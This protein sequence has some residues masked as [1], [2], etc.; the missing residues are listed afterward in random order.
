MKFIS[1]SGFLMTTKIISLLDVE[2]FL[3]GFLLLSLCAGILTY[4]KVGLARTFLLLS[5]Y[6][7]LLFGILFLN[8]SNN[9]LTTA[10]KSL[11]IIFFIFST[12]YLIIFYTY[13]KQGFLVVQTGYVLLLMLSILGMF[14][15]MLSEDLFFWFLAIELQSFTFY[16]L[17]AYQTNRAFLQTEAALK[18]FIFGS[19]ASSFLLYGLSIIFLETGSLQVV[20]IQTILLTTED[21]SQLRTGIILVLIA[22][23]IKLGCAPFHLWTPQ[24]YTNSAP[25]LTF[26]FLLLPKIP[27]FY[28]LYVF[29]SL[30]IQN[31]YSFIIIASLLI[32]TIYAFSSVIFRTFMA[33]SAIANNAFLLTPL[34]TNSLFS[35]EALI[36]YIVMYNIVLTSIFCV[37][38][39][40]RRYD[41]TPLINNLRDLALVK[42]TNLF[43]AISLAIAF[44][45]F[46]GIPPLIGFS[47]KIIVLTSSLSE[48][49]YTINLVLL[50]ASLLSAYYYLRVLKT[51]FFSSSLKYT[52][53]SSFPLSISYIL[54]LCLIINVIYVL[55]PIVL[56]TKSIS[57]YVLTPIQIYFMSKYKYHI[58]P[59]L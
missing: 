6:T 5:I 23:F 52:G 2:F 3:L 14:S 26:M 12:L 4:I 7:Y 58:I 16:A 25:I 19:I 22:L 46:S 9:I 31:I 53:T 44:L 35:L 47:A 15:V 59:G 45:N 17:C 40:L 37:V 50:I 32:G 54:S 36:S 28:I 24:V 20:D 42:K 39:F 43:L 55:T 48:S 13:I 10:S 56:V 1:A 49:L 33:Y 34:I 18:Y 11:L 29:S 41:G 57:P 38:L 27:L 51:M 8:N 21:S 30:Q